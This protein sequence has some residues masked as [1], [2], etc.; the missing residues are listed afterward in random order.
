MD[1]GICRRGWEWNGVTVTWYD[2]RAR[3]SLSQ[4]LSVFV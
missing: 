3:A 2:C 1:W 4:L